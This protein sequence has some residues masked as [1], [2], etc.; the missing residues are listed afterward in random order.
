MEVRARLG[1]LGSVGISCCRDCWFCTWVFCCS[2]E[3]LL[4]SWLNFWLDFIAV[5]A[6]LLLGFGRGGIAAFG[7]LA[8]GGRLIFPL[9][10]AA[11]LLT[12][13]AG[14]PFAKGFLISFKFKLADGGADSK[15]G[16]CSNFNFSLMLLGITGAIC[17]RS[18]DEEAMYSLA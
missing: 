14:A 6:L 8:E 7:G 15:D 10:L 16:M 18:E 3:A 1:C 4:A 5:G 11:I 17:D 13:S 12:V 9:T 2:F